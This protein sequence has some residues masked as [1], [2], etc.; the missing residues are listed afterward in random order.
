MASVRILVYSD[1]LHTR[2]DVIRSVGRKVGEHS[3]E[4]T[5]AA[6]H[7]GAILKVEEGSFDLLILDAEAGKLGGIGV[8]K[9]VRDEIDEHM[10]YIILVARP[11]D[12]WLARVAKPEVILEYPSNPRDLAQAVRSIVEAKVNA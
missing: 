3:I 5:E 4:W 1:N 7:E 10:P 12:R 9:T 2:E 8:G 6:T 11:Q